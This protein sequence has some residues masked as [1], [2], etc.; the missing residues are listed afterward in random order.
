MRGV[1]GAL[2]RV[3]LEEGRVI[4]TEKEWEQG[5]GE[6]RA[7]QDIGPLLHLTATEGSY[8]KALMRHVVAWVDEEP[9]KMRNTHRAQET[10]GLP[11]Q[12]VEK[13]TWTTLLMTMLLKMTLWMT[14]PLHRYHG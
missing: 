7:L 9:T 5:D 14:T 1:A 4:L 6:G 12:M 13:L 11:E 2:K 8:A 3:S 10:A